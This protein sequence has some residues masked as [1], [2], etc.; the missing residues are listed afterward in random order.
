[1]WGSWVDGKCTKDCGGT[2]TRKRYCNNPKPGLRGK[3]CVGTATQTIPCNMLECP[4][5]N[6]NFKSLKTS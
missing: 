4:K 2:K 3:Y 6:S 5:G 1:M